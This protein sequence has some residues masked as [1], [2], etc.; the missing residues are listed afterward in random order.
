MT[1]AN[2]FAM[3]T[4]ASLEA[5]VRELAGTI[6]E[7]NVIGRRRCARPPTTSRRPGARRAT[8][9]HPGL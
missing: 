6:G 8:G 3:A 4:A 2:G 9:D 1:N 5:H 7:R